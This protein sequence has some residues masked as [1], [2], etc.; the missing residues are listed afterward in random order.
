M[1]GTG[2]KDVRIVY[3]PGRLNATAD[4]LS[5]SPHAEPPLTGEGEHETQVSVVHSELATDS[6]GDSNGETIEELLIQPLRL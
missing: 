2:L 1:Y 5:R 3:R 6:N 4:A